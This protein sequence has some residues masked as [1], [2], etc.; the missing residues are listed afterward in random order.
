VQEDVIFN[1]KVNLK[2]EKFNGEWQEGA[3]P[4][5]VIEREYLFNTAEEAAAFVKELQNGND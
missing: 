5:E 4:V 1:V 2:L 3:V